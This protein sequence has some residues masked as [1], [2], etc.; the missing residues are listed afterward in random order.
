MRELTYCQD[1][2]VTDRSV[3]HGLA[4]ASGKIWLPNRGLAPSLLSAA[5]AF[6]RDGD[7]VPFDVENLRR[8]LEEDSRVVE[9]ERWEEDNRLLFDEGVLE[10]LPTSLENEE[11]GMVQDL[12]F[13]DVWGD[14]NPG[15][16]T[17]LALHCHVALRNIVP[18][19]PIFDAGGPVCSK[20]ELSAAR[21]LEVNVPKLQQCST[22][23]LLELRHK[24]QKLDVEAFWDMVDHYN[25]LTTPDRV[26]EKLQN[27][28]DAWRRDCLNVR[29]TGLVTAG[30]ISLCFVNS[31]LVPLAATVPVAALA[32]LQF[33]SQANIQWAERNRIEKQG[34][35]VVSAISQGTAF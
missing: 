5:D 20:E 8:E 12:D 34:F 3:L 4:I 11:E 28:L 13:K 23:E 6:E 17:R 26:V 19:V 9:I 7:D 33:L 21:V 16:T 1:V 35:K 10:R 32:G 22:E 24:F 29:G 25:R 14:W 31:N 15:I 30:M 18:G 2:I 27:D